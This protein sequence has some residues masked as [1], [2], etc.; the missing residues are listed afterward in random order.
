MDFRVLRSSIRSLGKMGNN[1]DQVFVSFIVVLGCH[2][3]LL[4]CVFSEY[5]SLFTGNVASAH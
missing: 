5:T 4:L 1:V 2:V 3:N